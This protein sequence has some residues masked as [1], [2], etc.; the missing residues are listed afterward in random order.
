MVIYNCKYGCCYS[1]DHKSK[2]SK[3]YLRKKPCVESVSVSGSVPDI[4]STLLLISKQLEVLISHK[5]EPVKAKVKVKVKAKDKPLINYKDPVVPESVYEEAATHNLLFIPHVIESIYFNE[6]Y[7][8]N[9]SITITNVKANTSKVNNGKVWKTIDTDQLISELICN[10]ELVFDELNGIDPIKYSCIDNYRN[11][12][13]PELE[14]DIKTKIT[15][16][17]VDYK[18]LINT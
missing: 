5:K 9:H 12:L 6:L 3:H 13:T 15:R 2:M 4:L 11:N 18:Y 10:F 7:P 14:K 8:E 17:L 1:T 16:L